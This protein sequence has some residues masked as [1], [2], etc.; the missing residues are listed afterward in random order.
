MK[1]ASRVYENRMLRDDMK[2]VFDKDSSKLMTVE[3]EFPN[4]GYEF[5]AYSLSELAM[6]AKTDDV[7]RDEFMRRVEPSLR[8]YVKYVCDVRT[9]LDYNAVYTTLIKA[10]NKVIDIYISSYGA[11]VENLL[12]KNFQ[13]YFNWFVKNEGVRYHRELAALGK[14]V[15]VSELTFFDSVKESEDVTSLILDKVDFERFMETL[16]KEEVDI[17][18][19]YRMSFSYR[20]IAEIM[21]VS[22]S[23]VAYRI[24]MLLKKF[25]KMREKK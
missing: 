24:N 5:E 11:P 2:L 6:I 17:L 3:A 9:F 19:M 1:H 18:S 14:K 16:S 25:K 20:E 22:S 15:C 10:A 13:S 23:T 12:R 8:H 7:A 21:A 4:L